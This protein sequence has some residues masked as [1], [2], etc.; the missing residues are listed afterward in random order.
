MQVLPPY[1]NSPIR[2]VSAPRRHDQHY[3][4]HYAENRR[5][6]ARWPPPRELR[7]VRVSVEVCHVQRQVPEDVAHLGTAPA[8]CVEQASECV[9]QV[10]GSRSLALLITKTSCLARF[11][12]RAVVRLIGEDLAGGPV[13][14]HHPKRAARHVVE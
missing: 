9:A 14:S 10:M 7:L 4:P 12:P 3:V 8:G 5:Q 13:A 11:P 1:Q 2:Y 6:V